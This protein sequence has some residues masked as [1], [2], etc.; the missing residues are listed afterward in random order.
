MDRGLNFSWTGSMSTNYGGSSEG[1]HPPYKGEAFPMQHEGH[2]GWTA[3]QVLTRA[4]S[5]IHTWMPEYDCSPTCTLIHLGTNDICRRVSADD[6]VRKLDEIINILQHEFQTTVLLAVPIPSCCSAVADQLAPAIPALGNASR[7][8]FIV[9]QNEDFNEGDLYDGCHPNL[10]GELKMAV[11]WLT[12]VLEHCNHNKID[13]ANTTKV[14]NSS[15][16]TVSKNCKF[17]SDDSGSRVN[18]KFPRIFF[19]SVMFGFFC[20]IR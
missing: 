7:R 2:W 15:G 3:E 13:T 18:S 17:V 20:S 1:L 10:S 19:A 11:K 12:Y 16:Q 4:G 8:V 9:H 14:N 5:N 6:V